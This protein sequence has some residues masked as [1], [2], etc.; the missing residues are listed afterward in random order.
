MRLQTLFASTI[1][2]AAIVLGGCAGGPPSSEPLTGSLY[3]GFTLID[4]ATQTVIENAWVVVDN[5]RISAFGSDEPPRGEFSDSTDM[6]GL[7]ALPGFIDVHG[8]LTAGPHAV[9]LIDGQPTITI[10]SEDEITEFHARMALAF[11]VTT[12]R[13][14][15]A[16]PEAS[17]AYDQRVSTGEWIGPRTYHAG[18][19]IQPP[20]FGGSAFAYPRTEEEWEAEAARQAA[21]GM[22]YF[23]LY[24]SLTEAELETGARVAR[25][26]GLEPI[27]HLDQVSWTRAAELGV[28]GFLHAMPTSADLLEPC[29]REEYIS[30]RGLDSRFMYQWFERVD[31]DGPLMQELFATLSATG[32]NVDLTLQVNALMTGPEGFERVYP[33]EDQ[34][35][36]HP[37]TLAGLQQFVAMSGADWT[38]EDTRRA[39]AALLRSYEFAQRLDSAGIPIGIGTDGPGGGPAYATELEL[40]ADAGFAPWRILELATVGSATMMGLDDATGRWGVGLD[41]D[42]VFLRANPLEDIAHARNAAWVMTDGALHSFEELT[43]DVQLQPEATVTRP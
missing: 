42:L 41:A 4:P 13:N 5:H 19:V 24:H 30:V 9:E 17:A 14:P 38:D 12:V 8:H 18:S 21:L 26:Y 11:G 7:F 37:R 32:A 20:P 29:A 33:V 34:P 43:W 28:K 36:I 16:D 10:E 23:K 22:T 39:E 40:M 27:A 35:Y 15:G 1:S 25:E 6:T 2:A 31:F 3:T